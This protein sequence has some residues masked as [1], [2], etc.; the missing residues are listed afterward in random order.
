M[1]IWCIAGFKLGKQDP[2]VSGWLTPVVKMLGIEHVL[3]VHRMA[4]IAVA[5]R[6]PVRLAASA[7]SHRAVRSVG[8]GHGLG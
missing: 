4:P 1:W 2:S 5:D 3:L 6:R 8:L 7:T